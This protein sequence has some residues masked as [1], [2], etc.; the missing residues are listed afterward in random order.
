MWDPAI[1]N[2]YPRFDHRFSAAGFTAMRFPG[3]SVANTY[4][5]NRAIGPLSHQGPNVHAHTAGPRAHGH[6]SV[7]S[8]AGCPLCTG[9]G[10]DELAAFG[11]SGGVQAMMLATFATGTAQWA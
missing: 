9:L 1:N 3:G 7:H 4:H 2:A 8:L 10:H 6:V 11:S 5:W